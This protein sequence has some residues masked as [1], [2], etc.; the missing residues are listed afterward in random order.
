MDSFKICGTSKPP[1]VFATFWELPPLFLHS[2]KAKRGRRSAAPGAAGRGLRLPRASASTAGSARGH[3]Q[4]HQPQDTVP[5][6]PAVYIFLKALFLRLQ[7]TQPQKSIRAIKKKGTNSHLPMALR[8][9]SQLLQAHISAFVRFLSLSA[10]PLRP[11]PAANPHRTRSGSQ[12]QARAVGNVRFKKVSYKM[13]GLHGD[14]GIVGS[15]SSNFK[16]Q[17]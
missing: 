8:K 7:K 17:F 1:T 9:Q 11:R 15:S 3:C 10:R 12:R 5:S 14:C 2:N 13:S 4:P 16:H 6:I